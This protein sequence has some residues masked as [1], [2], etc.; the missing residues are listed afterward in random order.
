MKYV[1]RKVPERNTEYLERLLPGAY[2]YNDVEHVGAIQS[3][4]NVLSE[5]NEDA[6]YIQDD[7]LLCKNFTEKAEEVISKYPYAVIVFSNFTHDTFT[8]HVKTQGWYSAK[9]GGWL[10]CTYIPCGI[11]NAFLSWYKSEN[12]KRRYA[13][14]AQRWIDRQYDDVLFSRF[15]ME[16]NLDVFVVIPN[17]A[18][19][20]KNESVIDKRPPKITPNFDYENAER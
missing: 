15:L 7:M 6:L 10:L 13:Q 18:G 1:I 19:H 2:V 5:I 4:L 17:L 12:W 3:F 20:P 16:N 14:W 9:E 8:R 11:K